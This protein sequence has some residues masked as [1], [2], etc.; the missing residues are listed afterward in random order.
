MSKKSK[1]AARQ[2]AA[3]VSAATP[4]PGGFDKWQKYLPAILIFAVLIDRGF[5][6]LIDRGFFSLIDRG[7]F[8][9][10]PALLPERSAVRPAS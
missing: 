8:S 4:A 10:R 7:F 2:K 6:S 1:S 5:F 9:L 3:S